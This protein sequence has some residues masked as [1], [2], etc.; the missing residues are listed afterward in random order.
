MQTLML[1]HSMYI[2]HS[3]SVDYE[4]AQGVRGARGHKAYLCVLKSE[5][6]WFDAKHGA[7]QSWIPWLVMPRT[8]SQRG[9]GVLFCFRRE[10]DSKWPVGQRPPTAR[11]TVL[12]N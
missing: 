6:K 5:L 2:P 11:S 9:E 10:T 4:T 12:D 8:G 7:G 1:S 3:A